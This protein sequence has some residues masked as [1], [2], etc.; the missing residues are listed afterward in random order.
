V[1][2][3]RVAVPGMGLMGCRELNLGLQNGPIG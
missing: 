1:A 3:F 2:R